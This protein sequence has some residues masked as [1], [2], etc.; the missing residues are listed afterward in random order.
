MQLRDKGACLA[1]TSPVFSTQQCTNSGRVAHTC[2]PR[3]QKVEVD[4]QEV[5]V[6]LGYILTKFKTSL[7]YMR[8]Y[9]KNK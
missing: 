3:T 9:L 4:D 5:K 1:C 7:S 2:N 6:F 8:P